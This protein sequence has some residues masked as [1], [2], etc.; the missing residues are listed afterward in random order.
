M[1]L[2]QLYIVSLK[3]KT[4]LLIVV[5][6]ARVIFVPI[7]E[8]IDF[9]QGGKM[10][11]LG[12]TPINVKKLEELLEFYPNTVDEQ[13]LLDGFTFGFKVNYEGSRCSYDSINLISAREHEQQLEEKII[14]R[15][16]KVELQDL[17]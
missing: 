16:G 9:A 13:I 3:E 11:Q 10:G 7:A 12:K 15:L 17:L 4:N 5:I 14:E 6:V 1:D 2:I 8:E